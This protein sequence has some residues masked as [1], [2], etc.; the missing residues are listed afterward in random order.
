[1]REGTTYS[2][3]LCTIQIGEL[4][5]T[6]EGP[7]SGAVLSPGIVVCITTTVGAEDADD[8]LDSGYTSMENGAALDVD[9]QE[10]DF[11]Y[12]QTVIRECWS[13]IKDGRDLGRSE[14]REVMMTPVATA[15]KG[16]ERDAAVRMWCEVLRMRG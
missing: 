8:N 3:G 5:A 4:R 15:K 7:Q 2:G 9:D 14:V 12:A 16:K 11:E 10:I 1:M 6:R 13:K